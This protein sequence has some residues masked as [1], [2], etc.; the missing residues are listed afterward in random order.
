MGENVTAAVERRRIHNQLMPDL[1]LIE[2]KEWFV[3]RAATT[4]FRV[5]AQASTFHGADCKL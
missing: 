3:L 1:T 2:R 4:N 5:D